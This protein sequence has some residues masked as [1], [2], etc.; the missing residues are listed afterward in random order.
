MLS[1]KSSTP[2]E[3]I[4]FH[5]W[6]SSVKQVVINVINPLLQKLLFHEFANAVGP[7]H[8]AEPDPSMP[9]NGMLGAGIVG[10]LMLTTP[11]SSLSATARAW[12]IFVLYTDDP[13]PKGVPFANVNASDSSQ[14]RKSIIAGSKI[15]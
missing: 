7:K 5:D 2:K 8:A 14:K 6:P 1:I 12:S 3:S 4:L 11:D 13:K 15:S 9:P 10:W